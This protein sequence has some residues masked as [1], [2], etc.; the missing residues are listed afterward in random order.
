MVRLPRILAKKE[1]REANVEN[2]ESPI[3]NNRNQLD[4]KSDLV[5]QPKKSWNRDINLG[6]KL[7]LIQKYVEYMDKYKPRTQG[8]FWI[9]SENFSKIILDITW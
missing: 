9:K 6:R 2:I 3:M 4:K 7:A 1:K 5:K 8:V